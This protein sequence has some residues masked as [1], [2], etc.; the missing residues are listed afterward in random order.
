MVEDQPPFSFRAPRLLRIGWNVVD[1]VGTHISG[2]RVSRALVVTDRVMRAAG[3]VDR[4][5]AALS[6]AGVESDVY[7][8]VNTE[9]DNRYC[10]EGLARLRQAE[11]QAVIGLGG[12]SPIDTAKSIAILAT[13]GG[14]I[15]DYMGQD[16]I[17]QPGLPIVAIPTTAGTGSE[18]TA[19]V[20]MGD[21]RNDVKML[22]GSPHLMPT[23]SLVD[24]SLTL[25]CP[26]K[27][28]ADT[29]VDSLT[30]AIEAYV[31]RRAN[32]ISD[33]FALSA[34]RRI[35]THLLRAYRDGTDREA[36][37]QMMLGATEAGLAFSN[38]SVALV[39]GMSR[40]IGANF[41]LAH[42]LSNAM[43]LP[44]VM[45]FSLESAP[46]RYA[47]LAVAMGLAED[48]ANPLAGA[49]WA[50]NAVRRLCQE[51]NVPTLTG[52]GLDPE[53]VMALAPKMARDALISGS[54]NNNPRIPS[55]QEIIELYRRAL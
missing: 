36:R 44:T 32:P 42:G 3:Y 29:G 23:L 34:T 45:E 2:L 9:P 20:A 26:P 41:H 15:Q 55:E 27:V 10:V 11:A 1:E 37:Y 30:H 24:P 35:Y 4:V 39:H 47:R 46:Q 7:E 51:L 21:S 49:R 33:T 14:E 43:L 17:P 16:R 52:A 8:G 13:N 12:G 54:P 53:R 28:T 5:C 22:I 48:P 6:A 40:P 50:L 19:F 31:S 18:V 38:A 25:S